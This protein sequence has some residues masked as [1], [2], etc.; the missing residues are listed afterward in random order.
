MGW[1][2]NKQIEF[3]L[4]ISLGRKEKDRDLPTSYLLQK[5]KPPLSTYSP[6]LQMYVQ[7]VKKHEIALS[8]QELSPIE[9]SCLLSYYAE[10]WRDPRRRLKEVRD[11]EGKQ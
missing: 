8:E 11:D 4:P 6:P 9:H 10:S 2:V 7:E 1:E 5:E 3:A